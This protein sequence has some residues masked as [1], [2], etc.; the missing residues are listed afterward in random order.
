M[1]GLFEIFLHSS[2]VSE[3]INIYR[4]KIIEPVYDDHIKQFWTSNDKFLI[5]FVR[6]FEK[7]NTSQNYL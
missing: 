4:L 1:T 3:T 5:R 7:N 2:N 6:I